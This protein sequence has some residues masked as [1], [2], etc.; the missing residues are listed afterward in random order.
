MKKG[1]TLVELLVVMAIVGVLAAAS[2]TLI[3]P[4]AQMNKARDS[5]RK[6]DIAQ[7]RAALELY[8]S[9]NGSYPATDWVNSQQGDG[10][11]PNLTPNYTKYVPKDPK[12]TGGFPFNGGYT[13]AYYSSNYCGLTPGSAYIL[14]IR[15]ENTSD[16]EYTTSMRYGSCDWGVAGVYTVG[17]P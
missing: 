17:S 10:W 16:P 14:A 5:K 15:L 12:N 7:I 3:N 4:V 1:F 9:D 2:I 8:R 6:A 13:Y 11:I